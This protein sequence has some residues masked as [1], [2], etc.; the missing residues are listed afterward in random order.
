MSRDPTTFQCFPAILKGFHHIV[1]SFS[2]NSKGI[3]INRQLFSFKQLVR[4][5]KTFHSFFAIKILKGFHNILSSSNNSIKREFHNIPMLSYQF[6]REYHIIPICYYNNPHEIPQHSSMFF[7]TNLYIFFILF[8]F[9]T[10]S[11]YN[12]PRFPKKIQ[13]NQQ[14]SN[15]LS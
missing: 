5:P 10:I 1:V 13:E 12:I 11:T 9:L 7:L 6:S 3:P 15:M 8:F 4:N 14:S 2:N